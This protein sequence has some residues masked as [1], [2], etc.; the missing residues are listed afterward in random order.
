MPRSIGMEDVPVSTARNQTRMTL[1]LNPIRSIFVIGVAVLATAFPRSASASCIALVK[2][3]VIVDVAECRAVNPQTDFPATDPRMSAISNLDTASKR[4]FYDSYR[5]Q[6][7]SGK[8]VK[9]DAIRSGFDRERGAL[10][11]QD[12][13]LFL[14]GAAGDCSNLAGQRVAGGLQEICCEGGAE[15]PCMLLTS[16]KLNEMKVLG[17]AGTAAGDKERRTAENEPAY[18]EAMKFMGQ[19]NYKQAVAKFNE[20]RQAGKLDVPGH[21]RLGLAYRQLDQCEKALSPLEHIRSEADAGKTWADQEAIVRRA[22]LLLARCYSKLNEPGKAVII[23]DGYLLEPKKFRAEI[24]QSLK[25]PDFGW[26]HTA[27]EYRDYEV[28]ARKALPRR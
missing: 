5:G 20:V 1:G 21:Y 28:R 9:S 26:I 17:P 2:G 11:G 6:V 27:K 12:V 16:Y 18:I 7:A 24:N 22:R 8:I 25:H 23:L 14:P 13:K 3:P 10:L 15:P 19:K 4:K